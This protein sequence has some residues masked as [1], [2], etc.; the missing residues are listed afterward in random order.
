MGV[1]VCVR[2]CVVSRDKQTEGALGVSALLNVVNLK[3]QCCKS[4]QANF[5]A[6]LWTQDNQLTP[7]A[8][9]SHPRC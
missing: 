4:Y 5:L 1:C 6:S 2:M 9:L 8:S 3:P 7:I